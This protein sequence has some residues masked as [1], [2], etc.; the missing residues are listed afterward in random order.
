MI[1]LTLPS[2]ELI[3]HYYTLQQFSGKVI[4]SVTKI[5]KTYMYKYIDIQVKTFKTNVYRIV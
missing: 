4:V 1:F 5:C 2:S 3:N